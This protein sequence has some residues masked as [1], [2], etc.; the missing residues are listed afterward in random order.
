MGELALRFEGLQDY[1]HYAVFRDALAGD[2]LR[3]AANSHHLSMFT[4]LQTAQRIDILQS[5]WDEY[6][7]AILN[8]QRIAQLGNALVDIERLEAYRQQMVELKTMAGDALVVAL[9]EQAVGQQHSTTRPVPSAGVAG[10]HNSEGPDGDRHGVDR[11]WAACAAS[12]RDLQHDG[13]AYLHP[14]KWHLG[15]T[16]A[17]RGQSNT[18][19]VPTPE[20][21]R[22][23]QA[24]A[25]GMLA[26]NQNVLARARKLVEEDVDSHSLTSMLDAQTAEV[27][28]L[29]D[30]LA[31]S[32]AEPE[33][34]QRLDDALVALR[35]GKREVLVKLHSTTRF[36][37][38][39]GLHYLHKQ[40]LVRVT[41]QGPRQPLAEGYL[42]E[43]RI[44]VLEAP[45]SERGKPLWAAHFH[46]NDAAA[47]PTAFGKGH[48]K[49]WRQRKLGYREQVRSAAM[50]EELRIHRG[51]LTYAQ[52]RG[53]IPF[54]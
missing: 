44:D 6:S 7:A 15:R 35:D 21:E 22:Q 50:G 51:N 31:D 47:A 12:A 20:S 27:Q 23:E 24:L 30:Q 54:H 34:L 13:T 39:E 17:C 43:Y 28:T 45:D 2:R 4:D 1:S 14:G 49:L 16:A 37:S 53:V 5:A 52:A 48:L 38:A 9:R 41:Y 33:L 8:S 32:E 19:R 25:E 40:G 36:P 29:R 26:Q 3:V 42:D 10:S 18:T 46:F 11:R